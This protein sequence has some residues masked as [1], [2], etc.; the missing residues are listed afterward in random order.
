MSSRTLFATVL[1]GVLGAVSWFLARN[2]QQTTP[3]Y[4]PPAHRVDYWVDGLDVTEMDDLGRPKYTLKA[5]KMVHFDDDE[6]KEL[7]EPRLTVH[8]PNS[9]PWQIDSDSGWIS[10]DSSLVLL[11]G[12]VVIEREGREMIR[13]IRAVTSEL[14]VKPKEDYAETDHHVRVDSAKNW[15]ESDGMQIWFQE[16]VYIKLLSRVKARYEVN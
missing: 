15:L 10:A 2:Q 11:H 13:P 1:L 6:S 3:V 14:R 12:R 5:I 8:K 9:P 4:D 7:T 16:P